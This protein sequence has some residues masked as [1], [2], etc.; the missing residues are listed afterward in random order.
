MGFFEAFLKKPLRRRF[1]RQ[2]SH[3]VAGGWGWGLLLPG[4]ILLLNGSDLMVSSNFCGCLHHVGVLV[5]CL[6]F[7]CLTK[8]P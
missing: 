8:G 6:A 5:V 1:Q 2:M 7:R 4:V 3:D